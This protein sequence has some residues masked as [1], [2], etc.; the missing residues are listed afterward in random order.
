MRVKRDKRDVNLNDNPSF[1]TKFR[2]E[3]ADRKDNL[4]PALLVISLG[5]SMLLG[6]LIGWLI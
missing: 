2:R 5:V 1:I 3:P 6:T 4:I